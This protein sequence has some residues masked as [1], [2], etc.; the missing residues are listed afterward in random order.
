MNLNELCLLY[1]KVAR[2]TLCG[3]G[4]GWG[5]RGGEGG[6]GTGEIKRKPSHNHTLRKMDFS[7]VLFIDRTKEKNRKTKGERRLMNSIHNTS[8]R[9]NDFQ[10]HHHGNICVF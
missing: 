7:L 4:L 1:H 8:L 10:L 2:K 3:K 6:G 5:V 9:C